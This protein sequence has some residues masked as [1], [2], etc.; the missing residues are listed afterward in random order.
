MEKVHT[1]GSVLRSFNANRM[2]PE[3]SNFN[4]ST[5]QGIIYVL[6]G[7]DPS[8]FLLA[9]VKSVEA[10]EN[11]ISAVQHAIFTTKLL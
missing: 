1:R 4:P 6:Y 7:Y 2:T 9:S 10:I 11:A 5:A 8:M 3:V